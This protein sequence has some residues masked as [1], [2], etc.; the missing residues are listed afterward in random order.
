[1]SGD[2]EEKTFSWEEVNK[3]NNS[4][5]LWLVVHDIVY[6]VTKFMEEHPGGEEVLLEQA[7]KDSTGSFEDVGHSPDAREMAESYRIGTVS[8]PAS[9]KVPTKLTPDT[10]GGEGGSWFW[11]AFILILLV[12]VASYFYRNYVN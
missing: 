7:G 8:Q 2:S 9:S 6:D 5:S 10:Q 3:H 4:E 1:M 12:V 11:P